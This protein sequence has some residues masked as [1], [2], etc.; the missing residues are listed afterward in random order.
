[1]DTS[2]AGLA[3]PEGGIVISA[4]SSAPAALRARLR[5]ARV[6][7][8]VSWRVALAPFAAAEAVG[9][10]PMFVADSALVPHIDSIGS[11]RFVVR[12][13]RTAV[14]IAGG[15]RRLLLMVVDGRQPPW[16]DGMTLR[17]MG[18][19]FL[20]LGASRAINLDGG[21]STEMVMNRGGVMSIVNR[22]SDQNERPV[23]NAI[24][25]VRRGGACPARKHGV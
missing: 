2:V 1:V 3:I 21:G 18:N 16:S 6:G 25:L 17:E 10:F 15:G 13:P 5:A 7:E 11:A 22:P 23:A 14:G 12:N 20:G 8:P 24:A 9:G 19:L 4:D